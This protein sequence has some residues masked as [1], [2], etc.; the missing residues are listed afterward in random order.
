MINFTGLN[1]CMPPMTTK[2]ISTTV[3]VFSMILN[4]S[5]T[6]NR[7]MTLIVL[8]R[9][10]MMAAEKAR[11]NSARLVAWPKETS[12]LVTVV[13]MFAPMIIGM[14]FCKERP[15]AATRH[16]MIDV[17]VDELWITL[18]ETMP[19]NRPRNGL[20]VVVRSLSVNPLPNNLNEWPRRF[21]L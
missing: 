8:N 14:A 6:G 2:Y 7:T 17:V 4:F 10:W 15:P 18:V 9:S 5:S 13:P 11:L 16:T 21:M 1:S 12:A 20:A 19:K 3:A